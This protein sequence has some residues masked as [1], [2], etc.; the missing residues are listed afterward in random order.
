MLRLRIIALVLGV[1]V[2]IPPAVSA[3]DPA[4]RG[5]AGGLGR[6]PDDRDDPAREDHGHGA[7][8]RRGGGDPGGLDRR[9]G[10]R[11]RRRT[12]RTAATRSRWSSPGSRRRSCRTCACAAATSA[13]GSPSSSPSSIRRSPSPA[14]R[15]RRPSTRAAAAFSTV[16]TREQIDALPDDPDEME[17]VLKAMSPPGAT[18][19][20]DG[21]TGGELPPKSQIRS[22]RLPKHGHVR[23]AEPRRHDRAHAHRHHDDA[24]ERAAAGERATSTS[25]TSR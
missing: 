5:R 18:I 2:I 15:S 16:L 8:C 10:R 9:H 4:R 20:V 6:R 12:C 7:G 17:E 13:A 14:T 19:R 24:G 22:I 11:R 3:E 23:G 1:L 21:F 25:W